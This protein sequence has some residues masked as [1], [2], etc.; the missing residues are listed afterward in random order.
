MVRTLLSPLRP[1]VRSLVGEL[2]SSKLHGQKKK[3]IGK[4][5]LDYAIYKIN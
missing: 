1:K 3:K 4:I 5:S 2:I